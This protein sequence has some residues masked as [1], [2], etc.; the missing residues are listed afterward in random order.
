MPSGRSFSTTA[1]ICAANPFQPSTPVTFGGLAMMMDVL[2][3]MRFS[4]IAFCSPSAVNDAV[5][6][7]VE[8]HLIPR[9]S[10]SLRT[11]LAAAGVQSKYRRVELDDLVAHLGDRGHRAREVFHQLRAYGV[12]FDA[13]GIFF[14]CASA[15]AASGSAPAMA[16]NVRRERGAIRFMRE[17]VAQIAR[18]VTNVTRG[19]CS[20]LSPAII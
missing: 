1:V 18:G 13:D 9:S 8:R 5:P 15:D 14:D 12:E 19:A 2:P 6:L 11:S 16:R 4:S 7:C 17:T 3:M 10:S 20:A